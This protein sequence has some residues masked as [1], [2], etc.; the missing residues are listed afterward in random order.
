MP[1]DINPEPAETEDEDVD[2]V[3][4]GVPAT[5]EAVEDWCVVNNS[6]AL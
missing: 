6:S 5:D 1:E 4:H 2:V 3:A